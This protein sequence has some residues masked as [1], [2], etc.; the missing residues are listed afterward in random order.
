M[1]YILFLGAFDDEEIVHVEGDVDPCRDLE[2]IHDELRLKDL[3]YLAKHLDPMERNVARG[4]DK[5]LKPEF[6]S[7]TL[8]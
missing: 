3:E 1:K 5:K 6:V 8:M 7:V 4:S 2:I